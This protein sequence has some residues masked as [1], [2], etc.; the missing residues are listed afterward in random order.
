MIL[1]QAVVIIF[2]LL[3]TVSTILWKINIWKDKD[4]FEYVSWLNKKY[5]IKYSDC[6]EAKYKPNMQTLVIRTDTRKLRVDMYC[7]HYNDF[8]DL[9]IDH[10]VEIIFD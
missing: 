7:V 2:S 3:F 5:E 9:L 6:K 1:I 10:D 4:C 8:V